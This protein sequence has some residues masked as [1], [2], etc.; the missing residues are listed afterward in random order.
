MDGTETNP[1]FSTGLSGMFGTTCTGKSTADMTQTRTL[2]T[3]FSRSDGVDC[4]ECGLDAAGTLGVLDE[5]A[6]LPLPVAPAILRVL[7]VPVDMFPAPLDLSAVSLLLLDTMDIVGVAPLI[8][9]VGNE[10]VDDD[11]PF[12]SCSNRRALV[13]EESADDDEGNEPLL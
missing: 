2:Q 3:P 4:R 11:R 7:L 9:D 8:V 12:P 1:I 10:C 5:S 6:V 13:T